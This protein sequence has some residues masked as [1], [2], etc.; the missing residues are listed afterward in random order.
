MK[1]NQ[2]EYNRK[3]VKIIY[4]VL[5]LHH[6]PIHKF[7]LSVDFVSSRVSLREGQSQEEYDRRLVKIIYEVLLLHGPIHKF[8]MSVDLVSSRDIDTWILFLT[9][10]GIKE[11]IL[12]KWEGREYKLPTC[13]FSCEGIT[14]LKLHRC[15][16]RVCLLTS[17]H[18]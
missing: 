3:L 8:E 9:R 18:V 1:A 13:L 12:E 11:I 7:E 5:L 14:R 15:I 6:G 2:E 16:V 10:N 4:E 17:L